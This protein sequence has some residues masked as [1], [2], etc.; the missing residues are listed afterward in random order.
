M[1]AMKMVNQ[2]LPSD[3]SGLPALLPLM[4]QVSVGTCVFCSCEC[5]FQGEIVETDDCEFEE[6]VTISEAFE[7]S[8]AVGCH[9]FSKMASDFDR[10]RKTK[11]KKSDLLKK[12]EQK[13]V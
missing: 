8:V 12:Q 4:D 9:S 2:L 10:E 13:W 6:S 1:W 11:L 3:K 5:I 7:T